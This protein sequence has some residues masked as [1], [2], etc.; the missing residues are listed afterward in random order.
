METIKLTLGDK[1]EVELYDNN[2]QRIHPLLVSQFE[3]FLPDGSME[4]HA[5]IQGGRIFPVHRGVEMD[6][7]YE[8][9][10]E[11]YKI[12]A[13]ALERNIDGRIYLL[14]V[15]PK[16]GE[17]HIQRRGFFRFGCILD[18]KYRMFAN[19]DTKA[20]DR[21]TFIK[22]ITK[23]ISGGGLCLL[24]NEK[25]VYGWYIEGNLDIGFNLNFIG[26]IVRVFD[27]RDKGKFKYETGVEFVDI[28]EMDREKVISF[29][30]D[31]QR[32]LLKKGWSTK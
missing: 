5:P 22:A 28:R 29:I 14:R 9:K 3:R 8:R 30:F 17:E 10:G 2:N 20:E 31:S 25:P 24:T 16:S 13:V 18:V 4:I 11:L 1:L 7:I 23:D 15:M 21:G 12:R 32:K 27:I 26:R 6:I 19:K